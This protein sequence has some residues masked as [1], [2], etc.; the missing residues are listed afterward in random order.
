MQKNLFY[1]KKKECE[2]ICLIEKKKMYLNDL[3]KGYLEELD[4]IDCEIFFSW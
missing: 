3:L 2:E 1:C 4:F